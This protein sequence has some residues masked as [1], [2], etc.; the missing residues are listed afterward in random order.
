MLSLKKQKLFKTIYTFSET[1]FDWVYPNSI[2]AGRGTP[3]R[4]QEGLL[5]N[6]QK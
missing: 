1:V 2:V 5:S 4:A 6:A 3:S